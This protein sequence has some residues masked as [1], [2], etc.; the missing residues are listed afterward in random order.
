MG[1]ATVSTAHEKNK[2]VV[3]NIISNLSYEAVKIVFG[4]VLPRLYLVNFGSDVNGLDSTIKNIFAY[5]ALLEAGVGLSAQY[6]L[7]HPV[8]IGDT[9]RINSILASASICA[10]A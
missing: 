2:R 6:S 5:L 7:Y 9:D 10:R 3:L 1:N 8:A 4:F